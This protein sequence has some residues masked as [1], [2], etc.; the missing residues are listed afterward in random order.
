[1]SS[2]SVN[3][4]PN[5]NNVEWIEEGC[6]QEIALQLKH[7]YTEEWNKIVKSKCVNLIMQKRSVLK[8]KDALT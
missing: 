4:N 2:Q 8:E 1:M 5:K 7:L 3:Q 6:L